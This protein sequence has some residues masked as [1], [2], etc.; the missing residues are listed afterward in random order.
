[1][2]NIQHYKKQICQP[3]YYNK[4]MK[5]FL[6][7]EKLWARFVAM[8]NGG[9]LTYVAIEKMLQCHKKA[10]YYR[11][12]IHVERPSPTF[13]LELTKESYRAA[14]A[15]YGRNAHGIFTNIFDI[16]IPDGWK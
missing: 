10:E 16:K 5:T 13:I 12:R 1:M 11:K 4:R 7:R 14:V 2:K 15:N 3:G 6:R 9:R 8:K